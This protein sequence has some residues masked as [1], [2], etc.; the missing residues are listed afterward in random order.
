M[1]DNNGRK[2]FVNRWICSAKSKSPMRNFYHRK[3]LQKRG[4]EDGF[5][6]CA[7]ACAYIGFKM[8]VLFYK[9]LRQRRSQMRLMTVSCPAFFVR[10]Y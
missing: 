7:A 3:E 8:D 1:R 6:I 2:F 4:V 10:N 9:L 5:E